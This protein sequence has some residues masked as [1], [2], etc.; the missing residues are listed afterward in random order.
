MRVQLCWK[1]KD[2]KAGKTNV[3][4]TITVAQARELYKDI[5]QVATEAYIRFWSGYH[6]QRYATLKSRR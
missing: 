6:Y 2:T 4:G 1:T 5:E 3:S